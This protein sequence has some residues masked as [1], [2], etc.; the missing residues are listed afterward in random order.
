MT[1]IDGFLQKIFCVVYAVCVSQKGS[2]KTCLSADLLSI[3]IFSVLHHQ[4]AF[5][6]YFIIN[7]CA[8]TD[9]L[10]NH[11]LFRMMQRFKLAVVK[12]QKLFQALPLFHKFFQEVVNCVVGQLRRF[13]RQGLQRF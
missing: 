11:L 8:I 12:I 3:I 10:V 4:Q 6:I 7:K 1:K 13:Q 2:K 5:M 9:A